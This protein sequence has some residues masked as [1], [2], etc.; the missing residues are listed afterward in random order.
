VYMT[1]G[2][3]GSGG[4]TDLTLQFICW[5]MT[6]QGNSTFHFYYQNNKFAKP[7]DYGLIK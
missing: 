1:G 7:P 4:G 5:D 3:G 2:A 6:I